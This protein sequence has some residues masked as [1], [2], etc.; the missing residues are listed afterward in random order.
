MEDSPK[1]DLVIIN[2]SG[3]MGA[4]TLSSVLEKWEYLNIPLKR[5]GLNDYLLGKRKIEDPYIKQR[6]RSGFEDGAVSYRRGG[7]GRN[8][9]EF[10]P[11][12][13]LIDFS[14]V[15]KKLDMLDRKKFSNLGVLYHDY[16][17]LFASA[18][19]YKEFDWNEYSHI[20]YFIGSDLQDLSADGMLEA[21]DKLIEAYDKNF[22]RVTWFHMT[23]NFDEWIEALC[24][25]YRALNTG[26][27]LD[28]AVRHYEDYSDVV[29]N[30]PGHIVDIDELMKPRILETEKRLTAII[31]HSRKKFDFFDEKFDIMGRI[32]D[33][34]TAFR[35]HDSKGSYLGPFVRSVIQFL[36]KCVPAG[37][38]RSVFFHPFYLT[39]MFI[40]RVKLKIKKTKNIKRK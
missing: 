8:A 32:V 20:E 21:Y 6:F 14:L 9:R 1:L 24:S 27:R 22:D 28:Q 34:D 33:S 26:F 30:I 35:K 4:S 38:H 23:R 3:P 29:N 7:I 2:S 36:V 10:A 37:K 5:L 18:I 15:E 11:S 25:Q 12:N 19:T 13:S 16:R 39:H 31:G 17:K 40:Y